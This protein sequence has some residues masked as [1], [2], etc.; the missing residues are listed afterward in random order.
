MCVKNHSFRNG[1]VAGSYQTAGTFLFDHTDPARSGRDEILMM[2]KRGYADS[3]LFCGLENCHLPIGFHV[4]IVDSDFQK[5]H[6]PH[7]SFSQQRQS[8]R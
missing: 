5:S 3:S 2:T 6:L 4:P 7:R 8:F 1:G